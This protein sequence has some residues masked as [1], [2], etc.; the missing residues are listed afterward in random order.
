MYIYLRVLLYCCVYGRES[1]VVIFLVCCCAVL[2]ME[3]IDSFLSY[4]ISFSH[5][6]VNSEKKILSSSSCPPARDSNENSHSSMASA[7]KETTYI[8]C[9][10]IFY[11]C[12]FISYDITHNIPYKLYVKKK[13]RSTQYSERIELSTWLEGWMDGK[14]M[15]EWDRNERKMRWCCCVGQRRPC[16]VS[17]FAII[18]TSKHWI[19]RRRRVDCEYEG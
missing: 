15:N 3:L 2:W 7:E 12:L 13:Q 5:Y 1:S 6:F 16:C 19:H 14:W 18:F 10:T 4:I 9:Y 11:I 8:T 17:P